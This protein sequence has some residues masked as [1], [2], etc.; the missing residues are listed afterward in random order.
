[1]AD[2]GTG[3]TDKNGIAM[4]TSNTIRFSKYIDIS[5]SAFANPDA[6]YF[7]YAADGYYREEGSAVPTPATGQ[8]AK[9]T[10]ATEG[11][12]STP[13]ATRG[14][15]DGFPSRIFVILTD[16]EVAILNADDLT[17]WI[18]FTRGASP[19]I[20][21][22]YFL[23]GSTSNLIDADFDEGV[24]TVV[25]TDYTTANPVVNLMIA[26]FRSDSM[27]RVGEVTG[28]NTLPNKTIVDRNAVIWATAGTHAITNFGTTGTTGPLPGRAAHSVSI[29][30]KLN[31]TYIATGTNEGLSITTLKLKSTG[32]DTSHTA[33]YPQSFSKT[34]AGGYA[35]VDDFDGDALTPYLT[36]PTSSA[37]HSDGI[38]AGDLVS[39]GTGAATAYHRIVS[40]GDSNLLTLTPEVSSTLTDAGSYRIVREVPALYFQSLLSLFYTTSNGAATQQQDQTYQSSKNILDPWTSPDYSAIIPS[41]RIHDL[42]VIGASLYVATNVGIYRVALTGSSSGLPA[43]LDYS[44]ASGAGIYKILD[45]ET[46]TALAVDPESGHL[47]A[48]TFDTGASK[49]KEIDIENFHQIVKTT[50]GTTEVFS[51]MGYT[52]PNGPPTISV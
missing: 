29:V 51:L 38:R 36:A 45:H 47:I 41:T 3:V 23:G 16:A 26:D 2:I 4:L 50:T 9:A 19:G 24:L 35:A 39:F 42:Q 21:A 10:W 25:A 12:H 22:Q 18:R 8:P 14:L 7:G 48:A 52:N 17:V 6:T 34:Y 1:M 20:T 49:V 27:L 33:N 5:T 13:T 28:D 11:E 44:S 15:E 32:Y 40:V 37:W 46:A 43:T 31:K 30:T